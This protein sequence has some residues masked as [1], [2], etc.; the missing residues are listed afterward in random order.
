MQIDEANLLER[1]DRLAS[2]V[3]LMAA[4]LGT[5]LDREQFAQ[6]LGVHRHTLRARLAVDRTMPRPGRDG[7]WPMAAQRDC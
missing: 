7:R 3:Q 5:R 6:R 4:M 1:I 2:A